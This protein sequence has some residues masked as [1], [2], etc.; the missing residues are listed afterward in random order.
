[1]GRACVMR[2]SPTLARSLPALASPEYRPD[3]TLDQWL[4]RVDDLMYQ[5]KSKG[6]DRVCYSGESAA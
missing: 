5:A 6:R 1:M 2:P 3:E 4:K